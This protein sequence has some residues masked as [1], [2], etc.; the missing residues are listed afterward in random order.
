MG[1]SAHTP[2]RR[3]VTKRIALYV[4]VA[5]LVVAAT[6]AAPSSVVLE[7]Q[8]ASRV[9]TVVV[10]GSLVSLTAQ[11]VSLADVLT[12]I[13]RETGIAVVL[14]GDVSGPVTQTVVNA[15][16]DEVVRRLTRGHSAVLVYDSAPDRP[17]GVVLTGVRVMGVASGRAAAVNGTPG[18]SGAPTY[19][20]HQVLLRSVRK[21]LAQ[22]RS[23]ELT[24][25]LRNA[26]PGNASRIVQ[27][28]LARGEPAVRILRTTAM[29]DPDPE[30]RRGAIR[31]LASLASDDAVE[32]VR[33][34]I[35]DAD[36][37]VRS[38]ALT[39]FRRLQSESQR[40]RPR[41]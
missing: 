29:T 1:P 26:A 21:E 8:Q 13:G 20:R 2:G 27:P 37:R 34:T 4:R 24:M 22:A 31:A 10:A 16:L 35:G 3:S 9:V 38:E 23:P 30:V 36:P 28:L 15:P 19:S 32:A 17:D 11:D 39:T 5:A 7:A 40:K 41:Q 6:V 14:K 12:A 18:E 33:A 25:A